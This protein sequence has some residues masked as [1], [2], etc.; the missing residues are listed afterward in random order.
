MALIQILRASRPVGL[1]AYSSI[2]W[3]PRDQRNAVDIATRAGE[4]RRE[5]VIILSEY[6][7]RVHRSKFSTITIQQVQYLNPPANFLPIYRC[8]IHDKVQ[9]AAFIS[10]YGNRISVFSLVSF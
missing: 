2:S 6:G 5:I 9:T 3:I 1:V 7:P 10:Y 4:R 8:A